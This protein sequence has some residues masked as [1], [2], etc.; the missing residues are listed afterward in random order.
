VITAEDAS[1]FGPHFSGSGRRARF[2]RAV[3]SRALP[4]LVIALAA[5]VLRLIGLRYGLP[6]VYNPDEVAIMSRALAF[7]KGDLNPHNF[8]YPTFY[9]YVLFAWEGLTALLAV[10]SGAVASFGA[11]QREFFV[12]PTRV[13]VAGRLL[14]ALLGTATVVAIG[15]LGARIAGRFVG[16]AAALVL[17]VA[18]LH[19]LNSHYVK[20]D[21]P[22]T[23]VIVLAYL[24]YERVW[25]GGSLFA[26]AAVTGVAFATHYYTIFLAIPLA[27]AIVHRSRDGGEAIRRVAL[28]A[29]IC[30]GVFFLLSPFVLVEPLTALGDIRANRQIVVDRAVANLGYVASAARYVKLLLSDAVGIPAAILALVG[31]II[32]ARRN[33]ARTAWLLAFTGPFLLFVFSTYP[34]SRYLVPATPF[35]ALFAAIAIE[36]IGK[37]RWGGRQI[38]N[39][40]L[41]VA[42]V[43]TALNE[44]LRA[45]FFI[46]HTDTRTLALEYITTR[47]PN[48]ATI[49]TQPYS[50]PLVPTVEVLREAVRRS[51]REMPTKTRL[52]IASE[53]YPSPSYRL[54]YL[55]KGLDAD[56]LYLPY[57]QLDGKDPLKAARA[58]H[59]AFVVLKRY[60]GS[61]PATLPFL[62]ALAREA[63]KIAVFSPYRDALVPGEA[64]A[65]LEPFLH[66][67]DARIIGALERPGPVVEIWQVDVP[68]F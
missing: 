43:A 51:E 33:P 29:A 32:G 8:L 41:I 50:V 15:V 38:V 67:T 68:N 12:D 44:S 9:F 26:A 14:T 52:Q 19:V 60:N 11:F 16:I 35:I 65:P 30:A 1:G 59:V 7:A 42:L 34:A 64:G 66:N 3:F 63:R 55:G 22:V 61:D 2:S 57:D 40:L 28:A 39:V 27:W 53:P 48:G 58:E 25:K 49:L 13:F 36:S 31:V 21:V 4:W 5:L 47:I 23:F 62:T 6:A 18:P 20:H 45:D 17:A 24:T 56:K 46:R 37:M 54:I 10:A